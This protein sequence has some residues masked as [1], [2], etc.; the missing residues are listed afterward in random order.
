MKTS[1]KPLGDIDIRDTPSHNTRSTAGKTSVVPKKTNSSPPRRGAKVKK[2][3]IDYTAETGTRPPQRT[4]QVV[5]L[6]GAMS[7]DE[8]RDARPSPHS[9][10]SGAVVNEAT[11][12]HDSSAP[13]NA[14]SEVNDES[15]DVP[16]S[17][18]ETTDA[19][20]PLQPSSSGA[21]GDDM[22]IIPDTVNETVLTHD[23]SAAHA[24]SAVDDESTTAARA[25]LC[26][27]MN[28]QY[29]M[30]DG[31]YSKPESARGTIDPRLAAAEAGDL[32]AAVEPPI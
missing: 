9:S 25:Y 11:S 19:G 8:A 6:S 3:K 22:D 21:V 23:S 32:K 17:T 27:W 26:T 7:I 12:P 13:P 18:D 15:N 4:E 10:S 2:N 24:S 29:N 28:P 14:S 20:P 1:R 31:H 5:T 16:M 30:L